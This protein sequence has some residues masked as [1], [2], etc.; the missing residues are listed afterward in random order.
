VAFIP[1]L[2]VVW[3][4]ITE[5]GK[6]EPVKLAALMAMF[7]EMT[8]LDYHP[9]LFVAIILMICGIYYLIH[10]T[11]SNPPLNSS[12]RFALRVRGGGGS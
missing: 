1:L 7:A 3:K 5:T 9:K 11:P 12:Q 10:D 2:I 4:E 6:E 8:Q